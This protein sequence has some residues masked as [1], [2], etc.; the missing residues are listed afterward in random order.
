MH[1]YGLSVAAQQEAAS[2]FHQKG[3][4]YA[5]YPGQSG[6]GISLIS[7]ERMSALAKS[8]GGWNKIAFLDHGWDNLQDVYGFCR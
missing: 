8:V 4:W 1:T 3:Y 6:M 7:P 2:S 5:D